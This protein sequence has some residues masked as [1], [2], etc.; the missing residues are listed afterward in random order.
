[1]MLLV[2]ILKKNKVG[3]NRPIFLRSNEITL[4]LNSSLL[5]VILVLFCIKGGVYISTT[6]IF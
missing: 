1:M 2:N 4:S 5:F 6:F 3:H